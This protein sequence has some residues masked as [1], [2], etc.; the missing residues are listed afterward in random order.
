MLDGSGQFAS[1]LY[2]EGG[3]PANG[4]DI[5]YQYSGT[6]NVKSGIKSIAVDF[7]KSVPAVSPTGNPS[8]AGSLM[9]SQRMPVSDNAR[10][11][12]YFFWFKMKPGVYQTKSKLLSSNLTVNIFTNN[13]ACHVGLEGGA[14]EYNNS[15][16]RQQLISGGFTTYKL[17]TKT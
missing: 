15:S 2:S 8:F 6:E 7:S 11:Y 5:Y 17:L 3:R 12:T 16:F 13:S 9:M 1:Y 4:S 10:T 14:D